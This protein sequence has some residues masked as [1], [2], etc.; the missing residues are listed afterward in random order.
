MDIVAC[1]RDAE[2]E[3][4]VAEKE[5]KR[6]E[7]RHGQ[8]Y[9]ERL[10]ELMNAMKK[11]QEVGEKAGVEFSQMAA[12]YDNPGFADMVGHC[13][14]SARKILREVLEQH[15]ILVETRRGVL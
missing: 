12:D 4:I 8:E 7:K 14:V 15:G 6:K 9:T 10:S 13:N 1:V 3:S 5:Q 11:Y 2:A